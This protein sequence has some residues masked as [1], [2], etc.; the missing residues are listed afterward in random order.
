[1]T[2]TLEAL[3]GADHPAPLAALDAL[4]VEA[5]ATLDD[6]LLALCTACIES[7]L[8]DHS[9]QPPRALTPR[10]QAFLAATEQ[11]VTSVSTLEDDQVARLR[12]FESAD[13]I[14]KFFCAL[15]AIDMHYRL[16]LVMPRVLP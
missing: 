14:Y 7:I 9:W 13:T 16:Q 11:F 2:I 15:Y 4:M 5:R 8:T 3:L 10:E 12:E 6:E 1:M